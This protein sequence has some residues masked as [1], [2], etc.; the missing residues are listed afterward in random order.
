MIAT[1]VMVIE[2]SITKE[3]RINVKSENPIRLIVNIST[4]GME[5]MRMA[6]TGKSQFLVH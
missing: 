1:S 6:V 3:E 2:D 4:R 5:V